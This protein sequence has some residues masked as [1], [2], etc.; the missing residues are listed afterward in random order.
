MRTYFPVCPKCKPNDAE[1]GEL[2]LRKT[3]KKSGKGSV[4]E[5]TFQC[6]K[7][8]F[9]LRIIELMVLPFYKYKKE[10]EKP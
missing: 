5:R 1:S 4:L 9:K 6:P 2:M 3:I 10:S 8:G 7:C